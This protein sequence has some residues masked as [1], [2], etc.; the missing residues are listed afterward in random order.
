MTDRLT[1]RALFGVEHALLFGNPVSSSSTHSLVAEV[2]EQRAA[3]AR[4]RGLLYEV[5]FAEN[6]PDGP[7]LALAVKYALDTDQ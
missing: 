1:E 4:V 7:T 5:E 2:R 3:I 6:K